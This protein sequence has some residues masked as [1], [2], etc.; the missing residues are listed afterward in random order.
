LLGKKQDEV[1]AMT[2]RYESGLTQL[3][4]AAEQVGIMSKELNA[5][6]PQLVVTQRETAEMLVIVEAESQKVEIQR[7]AVKIDEAIAN[8]KA[9]EAKVIK[10]ECESD[11]AV[12]LPALEAAMDALNTLKKTDIDLVKRFVFLLLEILIFQHEV[13]AGCCEDCYGR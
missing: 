4:S 1:N 5:L 7:A 8:K 9:S 11:L 13:T 10:E 6:Q 3:A 12:A 2:K